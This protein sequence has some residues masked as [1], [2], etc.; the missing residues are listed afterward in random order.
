[1]EIC[2]LAKIEELN[3][4]VDID[5]ETIGNRG[6]EE[7]IKKSITE[8]KC[9]VAQEDS[10]IKGFLIYNREFFEQSFIVLLMVSKKERKKGIASLLLEYFEKTVTTEKIFSSTNRSN[11][12]MQKVFRKNGYVESGFIDNLDEGDPE[13]VFFKK[14]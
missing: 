1:M 2:R 7:Y 13:I 5:S 10:D 8:G 6:R 4:I 3:K 12:I 11:E 9:I 14:I